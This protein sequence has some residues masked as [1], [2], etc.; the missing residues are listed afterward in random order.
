RA[1]RAP[2]LSPSPST[3]RGDPHAFSKVVSKQA[4]AERKRLRLEEKQLRRER[5]K[6]KKEERTKSKGKE[7]EEHH[8][9]VTY[10][11]GR[12]HEQQTKAKGKEKENSWSKKTA[13]GFVVRQA[14][15]IK[16]RH[17]KPRRPGQVKK[18]V[19]LYKEKATSGISIKRGGDK[20]G[21]GANASS[22]AGNLGGI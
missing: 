14:T 12:G 19:N 20:G 17:P 4:T 3:P 2:C 11:E 1:P 18:I 7:K 16:L 10:E 21:N 5:R 15:D 13:S 9:Q 22:S 8:Q 6:A